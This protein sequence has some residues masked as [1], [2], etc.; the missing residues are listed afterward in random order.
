MAK[1]DSHL[2]ESWVFTA[3]TATPDIPTFTEAYL[4]A[5]NLRVELNGSHLAGLADG[6]EHEFGRAFRCRLRLA[7]PVPQAQPHLIGM[8]I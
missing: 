3:K 6:Q 4:E 7:G 8:Q 1:T 5:V 2:I